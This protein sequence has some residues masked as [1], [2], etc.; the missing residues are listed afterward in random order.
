MPAICRVMGRAYC[1]VCNCCK[2]LKYHDED[3]SA[4]PGTPTD[5][6]PGSAEKLQLLR[7]RVERGEELWDA[8]DRVNFE[9]T[10]P[11]CVDPKIVMRVM[12][13]GANK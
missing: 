8:N 9:G 13:K 3:C 10:A 7:E 4:A 2:C 5:A 11:G 1:P 12:S 6:P